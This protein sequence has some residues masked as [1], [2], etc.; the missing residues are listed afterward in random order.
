MREYLAVLD[1]AVFGGATLVEPK[2]LAVADP[3]ARWT[4]T[5]RERAFFAHS[6]N[7]LI[8]LENAVI[9]DFEASGARLTDAARARAAHSSRLAGA[10]RRILLYHRVSSGRL[11]WARSQVGFLL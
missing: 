5:T 9:V 7:Y 11:A 2:Q 1:D 6:T 10:Q 4:A 8:D 3:A